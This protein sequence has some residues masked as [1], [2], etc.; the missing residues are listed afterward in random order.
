MCTGC[1]FYLTSR[2]TLRESLGDRYRKVVKKI[3]HI[4]RFTTLP[5]VPPY[6]HTM[7]SLHLSW[8]ESPWYV[9]KQVNRGKE[10]GRPCRGCFRAVLI[11]KRNFQWIYWKRIII[12]TPKGEYIPIGIAAAILS[13]PAVA[14]PNAVILE[15]NTLIEVLVPLQPSK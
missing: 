11:F 2:W 14:K 12:K 9:Q 5:A 8:C 15:G 10:Q 13:T 6:Q 1:P 7:T 3:H 4:D